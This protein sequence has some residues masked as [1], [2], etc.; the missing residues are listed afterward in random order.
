MSN[1]IAVV[2][3][4]RIEQLDSSA[5]IYERPETSFV[6]GFIGETNL[7]EGTL[8]SLDG[9]TGIILVKGTQI[10]AAVNF[11]AEP[12]DTITL[13]IRPERLQINAASTAGTNHLN[14]TIDDEIY[15]GS[16]SHY[17]AV[18]DDETVVSVE[19]QN[20]SD[21]P[22]YERGSRVKLIWMPDDAITFLKE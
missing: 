10:R 20:R 15:L 4:G 8:E 14:A 6:A 7:I 1:K 21:R 22:R 12:G 18:L 11:D 9:S 5:T 19:V 13:S 3:N 2:N 16:L 17:Q